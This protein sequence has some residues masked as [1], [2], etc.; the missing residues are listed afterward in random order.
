MG[1]NMHVGYQCTFISSVA[2]VPCR[3][4]ASPCSV[5]S[6]V[7]L[8]WHLLHVYV[9][10][11]VFLNDGV[12]NGPKWHTHRGVQQHPVYLQSGACWASK[13]IQKKHLKAQ[14]CLAWLVLGKLVVQDVIF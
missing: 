3:V 1:S 6:L 2:P 8:K 5:L 12:S 9:K 14:E 11:H 10:Q 13:D 7:P 4:A